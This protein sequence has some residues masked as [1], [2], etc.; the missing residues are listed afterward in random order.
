MTEDASL[1][2]SFDYGGYAAELAD[3]LRAAAARIL[4]RDQEQSEAIVDIGHTLLKVKRKVGRGKWGHWLRLEPSISAASA[5]RYMRV[6][7]WATE[8]NVT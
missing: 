7:R 2:T 5:G 4:A 6:A 8:K 1:P 3:E